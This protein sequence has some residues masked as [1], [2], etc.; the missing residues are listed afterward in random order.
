MNA[1]K[2]IVSLI[3]FEVLSGCNDQNQIKMLNK[4][5]ISKDLE[6]I[7]SFSLFQHSLFIKKKKINYSL[8]L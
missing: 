2:D 5:L 4:Y 1:E 8:F 6:C 7:N 3:A